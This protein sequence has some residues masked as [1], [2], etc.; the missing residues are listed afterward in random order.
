[1]E[2]SSMSA[3]FSRPS[4]DAIVVGARCAGAATAMLL[5]RQGVRVLLVE[6]D[7]HPG[8][9]LSTHALMRP[10]VTLLDNWGLLPAIRASGTPPVRKATFVY[11]HETVEVPIAP[12]GGAEGLY[13]PRRTVL[14]A[15]LRDMA[16]EAGAEYRAGIA[17]EGAVFDSGGRVTGARLRDRAGTLTHV[18]CGILIGADGRRS[19]VAAS[20]GA[21]VVEEAAACCAT[22]YGYVPGLPDEGYTWFFATGV[23]GGAIPTTGGE[24]CVFLSRPAQH[25]A[26]FGR[27][28]LAGL[29]T[30]LAI[31]SARIAE[32]VR[33][34]TP[35]LR[36]FA[37]APGHLRD[38]AGPGWA[39]VGDAGYFKDPVTAHGITD[40]LLDAHRLAH[41]LSR[42][43]GAA[44][45]REARD[46]HAPAMLALTHRIA[47]LDCAMDDLAAMHR[48]FAGLMKAEAADIVP[49][50]K[51]RAA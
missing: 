23:A 28:A 24:H 18:S 47:A 38:C 40:A 8:D 6:R 1:M 33:A 35:R 7:P 20:V 41:A 15:I 29:A 19:A 16:C 46:R 42:P 2:G 25:A 10:A 30:G 37:G 9:T 49:D 13:A 51:R 22:V 26:G 44:L 21:R 27:D 17:F 4:Y 43:G 12:L 39:L 32:A 11:G 14:D 34:T 3:T 50:P 36:R 5:A 45:Y 31:W 48:D